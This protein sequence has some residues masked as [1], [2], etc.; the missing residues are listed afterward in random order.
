MKVAETIGIAQAALQK[1][2]REW[3]GL[4]NV[5]FPVS[6]EVKAREQQGL[7]PEQV[8]F[9]WLCRIM[10]WANLAVLEASHRRNPRGRMLRA[11]CE[12]ATNFVG[13]I[14]W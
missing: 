13:A 11:V 10:F 3:R 6:Q 4:A 5:D 8:H 12:V 14:S 2:C 9:V 1:S 7:K